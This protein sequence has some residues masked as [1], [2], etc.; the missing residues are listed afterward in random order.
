MHK[1]G[2]ISFNNNQQEKEDFLVQLEER[3][4]FH[5]YIKFDV[6]VNAS[7]Y[8]EKTYH[9]IHFSSDLILSPV[10]VKNTP[11]RTWT[12][13][14]SHW[15]PGNAFIQRDVR[16]WRV[17]ICDWLHQNDHLSQ[18][19][20]LRSI[21]MVYTCNSAAWDRELANEEPS[22]RPG[23]DSNGIWQTGPL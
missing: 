3:I 10:S 2:H 21:V 11:K 9:L 14:I 6:K 15:H 12:Q 17:S 22:H 19:C 7:Y 18:D 16:D 5:Q 20:R 4:H 1:T 8:E 23:M 13:T